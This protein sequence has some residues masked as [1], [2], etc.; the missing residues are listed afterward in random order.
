MAEQVIPGPIENSPKKGKD[1]KGFPIDLAS[2]D[3]LYVRRAMCTRF[4]LDLDWHTGS[5]VCGSL[6]FQGA[7]V[8]LDDNRAGATALGL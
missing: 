1:M 7:A 8:V 5:D 6:D 3:W 4:I 2:V